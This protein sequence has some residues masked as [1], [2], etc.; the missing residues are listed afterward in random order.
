MSASERK[1]FWFTT[2]LGLALLDFVIAVCCLLAKGHHA[3]LVCAVVTMFIIVALSVMGAMSWCMIP[4]KMH[5]RLRNWWHKMCCRWWKVPYQPL[6]DKP[7]VKHP[8]DAVPT[9]ISP[10]TSGDVVVVRAMTLDSFHALL[11]QHKL[12]PRVPGEE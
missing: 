6:P 7:A 4:N 9:G 2:I 12:S 5:L 3:A 11:A 8:T 10:L 1:L